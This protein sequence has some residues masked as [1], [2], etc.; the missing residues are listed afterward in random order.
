MRED[1]YQ[2]I[3]GQFT[4]GM[5]LGYIAIM[6]IGVAISLLIDVKDRDKGSK[7]SPR[8]FSWWFLITDNVKRFISVLLILYVFIRFSD[9]LFQGQPLDWVL[10]VMGYNFDNFI[11]KGRKEFN[12]LKK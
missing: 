6:L 5:F 7:R 4:P 2:I 11:A 3:L 8:N 10:L 9:M 12:I 1:F